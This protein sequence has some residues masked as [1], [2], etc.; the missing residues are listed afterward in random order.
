MTPE[1][2]KIW[3][4]NFKVKYYNKIHEKHRC[5]TCKGSYSYFNKSKHLKSKKHLKGEVKILEPNLIDI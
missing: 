3:Y 4:D 2:Y 5:N 1:N